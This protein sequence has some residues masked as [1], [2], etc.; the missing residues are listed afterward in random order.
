MYRYHVMT[1]DV[2]KVLKVLVSHPKQRPHRAG[3]FINVPCFPLT[4]VVAQK[5]AVKTGVRVLHQLD[6]EIQ[7]RQDVKGVT[8]ICR[9]R[10]K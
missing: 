9:E 5:G 4:S 3:A 7:E 2:E 1:G 6:L 10:T 8:Y